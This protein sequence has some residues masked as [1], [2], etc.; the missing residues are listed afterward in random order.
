MSS[1]SGR[2]SFFLRPCNQPLYST[3]T[4]VRGL[5]VP[6]SRPRW[7]TGRAG[8][9][10]SLLRDGSRTSRRRNWR[11]QARGRRQPR[12][13][14]A[15]RSPARQRSP[16]GARVRGRSRPARPE[17][18]STLDRG[19]MWPNGSELVQRISRKH[20]LCIPKTRVRALPN[21]PAPSQTYVSVYRI[22]HQVSSPTSDCTESPGESAHLGLRRGA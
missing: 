19:S 20:H 13:R 4:R 14:D 15:V 10:Y 12:T 17:A 22:T 21:G 18:C 11:D 2:L 5:G 7:P 1:T 8:S 16:T 9:S 3:P 6:P